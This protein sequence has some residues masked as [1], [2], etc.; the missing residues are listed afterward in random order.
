MTYQEPSP[1][2]KAFYTKT[3]V[4]A[5]VEFLLAE[6]TRHL[7]E[8]AKIDERLRGI[9]IVTVAQETDEPAQILQIG[10]RYVTYSPTPVE[11]VQ[12]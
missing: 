6:R 4:I 2:K 12:K 8:A 10:D 5:N 11:D 3:P 1:I 9:A 7:S